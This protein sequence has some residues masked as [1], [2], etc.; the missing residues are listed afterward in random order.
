MASAWTRSALLRAHWRGFRAAPC[1]NITVQHIVHSANGSIAV[2]QIRP[3]NDY[4]TA[5][6]DFTQP[7]EW[8][9][10]LAIALASSLVALIELAVC[11]SALPTDYRNF[12]ISF[13]PLPPYDMQ[14]ISCCIIM[15]SS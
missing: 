9:K 2:D 15:A 13:C 7:P 12:S 6:Q 1:R 3:Q 10:L 4:S 5:E 8:V 11:R 14:T